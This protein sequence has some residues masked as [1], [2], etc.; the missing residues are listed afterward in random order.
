MKILFIHEVNWQKKVTYEIHELPE[1]FSLNGHDVRFIDFPEDEFPSGIRRL[2]DLKKKVQKIRSRTYEGS[3]IILI[4][5]GRV[6][7]NPLDRFFASISHI[8]ALIHEFRNNRPDVVFL[9][10]VPTNGWLAVFLARRY[11]IPIVYRAIDIPHLIRDT[12]T[13]KLITMSE[14]YVYKR[15]QMVTAN[16]QAMRNY[17]VGMGTQTDKC[18]VNL[19]GLDLESFRKRLNLIDREELGFKVDDKVILYLGTFFRFGGLEKFIKMIVPTLLDDPDMKL[20]LVGGGEQENS[21]R[22]LIETT[23]IEKQIVLT[24]FVPY[25]DVAKYIQ[26]SNVGIVTF[27]LLEVA[28]AALPWKAIQ[29]IASGIPVVSTP[30][31]GLMSV[32]A[33]GEGIAYRSLDDSF[34]RA[35]LDIL[36]NQINC[37]EMVLKGI[38][39]LEEKFSWDKNFLEFENLLVDVIKN[40]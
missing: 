9:Y 3:H 15:V 27:D 16:N 7:R 31:E 6:F 22:Q 40:G 18:I 26:I 14:R 29:Y 1:L 19:P 10:S 30:L 32:L 5:P 38:E 28:H 17:C 20:L 11:R 35:L 13:K 33:E 36:T 37:R 25:D 21:I 34:E 12:R 2:I 8:P 39:A 4:T 23:G 24:G